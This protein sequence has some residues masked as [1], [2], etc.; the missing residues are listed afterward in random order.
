MMIE[1]IKDALTLAG[2]IVCYAIVMVFIAI[3]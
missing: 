1:L 3:L 2:L